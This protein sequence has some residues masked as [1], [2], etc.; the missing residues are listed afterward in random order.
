MRRARPVLVVAIGMLLAGCSVAPQPEPA[1]EEQGPEVPKSENVSSLLVLDGREVEADGSRQGRGA[2]TAR[3]AAEAEAKRA[4]VQAGDAALPA[5]QLNDDGTLDDGPDPFE[6]RSVQVQ[7]IPIEDD[8]SST[9]EVDAFAGQLRRVDP[10]QW[11]R[12]MDSDQGSPWRQ[13]ADPATDSLV[14]VT[15]QRC[16]GARTVATGVVLANETVVTTVH[17]IESAERRVRISPGGNDGRRLA[18][19]V[20]YLDVDDDIAV[21]KVPG[22][23]AR[24]MTFHGASGGDPVWGYAYGVS[25]GGRAGVMRRTPAIVATETESLELEQPD[26]YARRISD[27]DVYPMVGAVDTG[28][29]GGVV[30]AT[31]DRNLVRGFGFHGLI[32]ARVPFRSQT[33]GI[34]VPAPL[35]RDALTASSALDPWFEHRPGDCPQWRR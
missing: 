25:Q 31:A 5:P 2:A 24:P 27:R 29:S 16:G 9:A 11:E 3:P 17:A 12:W 22:L 26:G 35:V 32:R 34:V 8:A 14:K 23:R 18:G 4:Q 19:M 33:G 20:R 30:M 6:G 15:V 28:F 21:L 1:D 13:Y 10:D 7:A